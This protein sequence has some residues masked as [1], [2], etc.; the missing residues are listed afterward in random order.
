MSYSLR[1]VEEAVVERILGLNP[2]SGNIEPYEQAGMQARWS[3]ERSAGLTLQS[4][5][6]VAHLTFQVAIEGSV[7]EGSTR[8]TSG[9]VEMVRSRLGVMFA[10]YLRPASQVA[11]R[12]VALDAA[13]DLV[14]AI[15]ALDKHDFMTEL[16]EA[17][18]VAI[19]DTDRP[20]LVVRLMF[21]VLHEI[22]V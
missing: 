20:M 9:D 18:R 15:N 1:Q 21:D 5:A 6:E 19:T 11:D 12:R 14:R 2:E 16:V 8:G 7:S 3:E 13:N 17:A 10:Y 4:P 22:E